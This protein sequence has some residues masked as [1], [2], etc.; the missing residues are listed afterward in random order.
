FLFLTV[1]V[2]GQYLFKITRYIALG[3]PFLPVAEL[4]AL[5]V[6]TAIVFCLPMAMLLASLLAFARLSEESA[7]TAIQAGGIPSYRCV[8]A[9]IGF[10]L[11]LSLASFLLNERVVPPAGRQCRK[12]EESIQLTVQSELARQVGA[13]KLMVV[14]EFDKEQDL[15]S[16]VVLA[17]SFDP[18]AG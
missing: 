7:L 18:L 11:A 1:L 9:S 10:G 2:S 4:F 15:P 5:R 12:L 6:V 16:R 13:Q 8:Y 3:A 14:Q 17:R